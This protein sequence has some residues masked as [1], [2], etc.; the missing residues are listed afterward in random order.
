MG[1]ISRRRFVAMLATVPFS[2]VVSV[3][4][5][6]TAQANSL[7]PKKIEAVELILRR[8]ID[9]GAV[10]GVSYSIGNRSKTLAEGAFGL[11]AIDPRAPMETATHCPLASVS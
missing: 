2:R 9:S 10:P 8:L 7:D 6:A 4:A 1:S 5:S 3:T 11:R